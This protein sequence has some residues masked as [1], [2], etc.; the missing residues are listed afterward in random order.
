M[1]WILLMF[2]NVQACFSIVAQNKTPAFCNLDTHLHTEFFLG[3]Y[4]YWNHFNNNSTKIQQAN[5]NLSSKEFVWGDLRNSLYY[6]KHEDWTSLTLPGLLRKKKKKE[7]MTNQSSLQVGEGEEGR[8]E[9]D[10]ATS[11]CWAF[12][13][14]LTVNI[15]SKNIN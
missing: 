9:K 12:A 7:E 5:V 4:I 1:K 11:S 10:C 15:F 3:S 14:G 8:T 2:F 6:L 13:W